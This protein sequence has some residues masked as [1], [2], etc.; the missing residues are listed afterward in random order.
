MFLVY[1][2]CFVSGYLPKLKW[3]MALAF[4]AD[5]LYMYSIKMF[6]TKYHIS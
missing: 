1:I 4:S 5:F 3:G 2:C 6:L